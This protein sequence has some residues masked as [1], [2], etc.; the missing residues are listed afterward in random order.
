VSWI[1]KVHRMTPQEFPFDHAVLGR[2]CVF[3]D[4]NTPFQPLLRYSNEN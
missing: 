4:V 2:V 3:I 1:F